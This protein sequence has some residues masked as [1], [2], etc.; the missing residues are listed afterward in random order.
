MLQKRIH[1]INNCFRKEIIHLC[2]NSCENC[3]VHHINKCR[4]LLRNKSKFLELKKKCKKII[5]TEN[6]MLS[7]YFYLLSYC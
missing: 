2:R 1:H 5:N 4:E 7:F 3:C 6:E